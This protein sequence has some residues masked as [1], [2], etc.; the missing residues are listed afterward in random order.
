M[1][2]ASWKITTSSD[3]LQEGLF[4]QIILWIFELLP[5][6]HRRGIFPIWDIKSRLY[7]TE[8]GYTVIPGVFDLA[9][10]ASAGSYA[11]VDFLTL[12]NAHVSV[13]GS[14]WVYL[15]R[16]WESYFRVPDRTQD[17]ADLIGLPPDTLGVHY[18]GTDK[19]QNSWDSN[20]V[21]QE[22]F[23]TLV[24]DFLETHQNVSSVFLATDEFSFVDKALRRLSRLRI[25]NLGEVGFH[26]A[27]QNVPHKG[28]RALLDC[29]VL[30]RC[31]YLLKCSSALSGFAKVLNPQLES[32]R[33][34]ASKL[35][36][37][38]PY[39]PEAYIPK[40][41]STDSECRRILERQFA[42]DWLEDPY[43]RVRFGRP[44]RT[45]SRYG[46]SARL[47]TWLGSVMPRNS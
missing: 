37:D 5:Y 17:A 2:P 11:V 13:L 44:F 14:D 18:R 30:S 28:D 16:L 15:N 25:I 38:I 31:R 24:E 23:L 42:N 33:L 43:A 34:S 29:L 35:F 41:T 6:L 10:S 9:Y 47:R 32:Y 40:L 21:S 46:L 19:N 22:D 45:Q 26:K 39:F 20:P 7:G 36:T 4:G 1:K 27:S 12:R 3:E 8:P